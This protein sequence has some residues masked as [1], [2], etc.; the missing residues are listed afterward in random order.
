MKNG[1]GKGGKEKS[2]ET[3]RKKNYSEISIILNTICV[4]G[5]GKMSE[6]FYA[7]NV[8]TLFSNEKLF[9]EVVEMLDRAREQETISEQ[10]FNGLIIRDIKVIDGEK[11]E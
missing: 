6:T 8:A 5:E 3:E 7:N 10:D 4:Q 1:S 9:N 11:V 2:V